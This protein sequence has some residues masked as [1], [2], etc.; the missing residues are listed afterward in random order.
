MACC[1]RQKTKVPPGYCPMCGWLLRPKPNGRPG[2][3][4]QNHK[5]RFAPAEKKHEDK[6]E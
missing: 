1:G 6:T 2:M 5:C 4:C 3:V